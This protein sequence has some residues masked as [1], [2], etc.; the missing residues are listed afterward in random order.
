MSTNAPSTSSYDKAT[1]TLTIT[2]TGVAAATGSLSSTG[3]SLN[4]AYEGGKFTDA[5]GRV[6]NF[7]CNV[8]TKA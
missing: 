2:V 8:H 7:G 3:K 6:V 5:N 1:D 4:L